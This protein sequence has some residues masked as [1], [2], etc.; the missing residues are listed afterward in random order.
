MPQNLVDLI[1]QGRLLE[2]IDKAYAQLDELNARL[3]AWEA[4]NPEAARI[5]PWREAREAWKAAGRP[6]PPWYE[7]LRWCGEQ[8]L[9]PLLAHEVD[10][11]LLNSNMRTAA[12][13]RAMKKQNDKR[14]ASNTGIRWQIACAPAAGR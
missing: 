7:V 5:V 3:D 12:G 2:T 14:R 10:K 9:T 13:K 8:T 1:R 11:D 6:L 4:R